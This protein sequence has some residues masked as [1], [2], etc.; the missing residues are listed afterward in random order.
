MLGKMRRESEEKEDGFIN[1]VQS[2]FCC[3]IALFC[4]QLADHVHIRDQLGFIDHSVVVR[5]R[6]VRFFCKKWMKIWDTHGMLFKLLNGVFRAKPFYIK[7]VLKY[8]INPF[9]SL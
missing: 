7:V 2:P 9:S 1:S 6:S 4:N 3:S 8:Q 5:V